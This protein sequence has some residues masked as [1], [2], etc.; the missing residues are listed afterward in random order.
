MTATVVIGKPMTLKVVIWCWGRRGGAP[1]HTLELVKALQAC[2]DLELSVS[3]SRQS[4]RYRDFFGLGLPCHG[5]DTWKG[6]GRLGLLASFLRL[7]F[8]ALSFARF[9]RRQKA[10]I[11]F[12]SF[13]HPWNPLVLPLVQRKSR[14][15][16][17]M[18]HDGLRHSDDKSSSPQFWL[19]L[20]V[21]MADAFVTMSDHVKSQLVACKSV[22]ED[23][24]LRVPMGSYPAASGGLEPRSVGT[25]ARRLLLFGRIERYK[26]I[27]MALEAFALLR[28]ARPDATLHIAGSG[29]FSPYRGRAAEIEGV[30]T[31]I[32]Y[33]GEE[34]IPFLLAA[35]DILVLPYQEATQSGVVSVANSAGVPVVATPVGGLVEQIKDGETGILAKGLTP[36][37]FCEA[38]LRL[39]DDPELYSHISYESRVQ[40][41]TLWPEAASLIDGFLHKIAG[42]KQIG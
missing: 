42:E 32:R 17:L 20:E 7:P 33:I 9:V 25:P 2:T 39:M 23:R 16:V 37:D 38:L 6:T 12:A 8:A 34:E 18:V 21:K 19:D 3:L 29:D 13:S 24:V 31:D 27:T 15:Y 22:S 28:A 30:T 41:E 5:V 1:N 35:H 26:G 4:D 10:D 14:P 40:G 11:V 36:A